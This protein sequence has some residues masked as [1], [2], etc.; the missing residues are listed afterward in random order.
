MKCIACGSTALVTGTISD[1]SSGGS[2]IFKPD[3]V[4][5]WKS[6]FGVGSRK[7][8]AYGCVH[9]QHLQLSAD[10]SEKDVQRY[11]QFE[12]ERPSVL[13][14]INSEPKSLED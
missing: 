1:N 11:N 7:V 13:E 12:G 6:M 10:F 8:R 5:I 3:D 9:C 14:L 4:S 2:I